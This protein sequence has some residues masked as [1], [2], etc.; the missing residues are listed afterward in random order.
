VFRNSHGFTLIE[1][2]VAIIILMVGLLGL[3]QAV[4]MGLVHNLNSQLRNEAVV[5]ADA[6]MARELNK[7]FD[8]VSTSSGNFSEQ[9][10][11]LNGFKN[12]SVQRT[13]S[14]LSNSKQVSFTVRWRYKGTRYSHETNT[15]V[16][17]SQ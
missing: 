13:G 11:I 16:S 14:T 8:L 10:Q 4:N 17:K 15:V 1:F 7:S 2:L 6:Y 9:R 5:V 3:L 12:Y